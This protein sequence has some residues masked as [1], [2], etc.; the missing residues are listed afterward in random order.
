MKCKLPKHKQPVVKDVFLSTQLDSNQEKKNKRNSNSKAINYCSLKDA[1]ENVSSRSAYAFIG[2]EKSK[3][4]FQ[5]L[6]RL[7]ITAQQVNN[8]VFVR[9]YL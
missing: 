4:I 3:S 2:D 5:A 9:R 1:I 7:L 8:F 6:E